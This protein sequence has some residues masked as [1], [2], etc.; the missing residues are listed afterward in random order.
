MDVAIIAE[1]ELRIKF[2][3][4][5][6]T[7]IPS[8]SK[9]FRALALGHKGTQVCNWHCVTHTNVIEIGGI[10]C[11]RKRDRDLCDSAL[12][13]ETYRIAKLLTNL[14]FREDIRKNLHT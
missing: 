8:Q 4:F 13:Q 12:R 5:N 3:R 10:G 14:F 11:K 2:R 6:P 1:S 9:T 7:I